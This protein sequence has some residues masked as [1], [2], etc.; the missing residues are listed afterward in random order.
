MSEEEERWVWKNANNSFSQG[1]T[2]F[3]EFIVPATVVIVY[4]VYLFLYSGPGEV[5]GS[6]SRSGK[7]DQIILFSWM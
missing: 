7:Y 1:K 3:K 5:G 4:F 6:N 2:L